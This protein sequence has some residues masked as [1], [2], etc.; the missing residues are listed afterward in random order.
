MFNVINGRRPEA[1]FL[2]RAD[3]LLPIWVCSV[4]SIVQAV[5]PSQ[6]TGRITV[7]FIYSLRP[8]LLLSERSTETET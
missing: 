7:T 4:P 6:G 5:H 3:L 2:G 8:L 1:R